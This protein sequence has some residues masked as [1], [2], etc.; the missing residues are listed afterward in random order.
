M[1][2]DFSQVL[3]SNWLSKDDVTTLGTEAIISKITPEEV[4]DPPVE[5]YALHFHGD[6][7]PLLLNPTNIRILV[8][9][10]GPL[11]DDWL[12]QPIIVY[13]D[14]TV[15]YAGRIAG[16]VRLRMAVQS[17]APVRPPPTNQEEVEYMKHV[18]RTRAH[19]PEPEH[20]PRQRAQ[21]PPRREVTY[22]TRAEALA[23]GS[24]DNMESDIPF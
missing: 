2:I 11:S 1:N 19:L 12:N 18:P 14:P 21:L 3:A 9:L 4:G 22:A 7:K 24:F 6:L 16:G 5:K 8:A 23:A 17:Q 13:S 20:A 10:Y 15:S